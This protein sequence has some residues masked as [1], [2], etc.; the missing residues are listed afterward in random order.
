MLRTFGHDPV[1]AIGGEDALDFLEHDR[2]FDLMIVDL[3]MPNML[4]DEFAARARELIPDVPDTIRDRLCRAGSNPAAAW[5]RYTE[6]AVPTSPV[7]RKTAV[8]I[9][10][11]G[12]TE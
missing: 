7:G 10:H 6:K 2:Q 1:E 8:D 11:R 5:G 4:G 9:G 3:A 12:A